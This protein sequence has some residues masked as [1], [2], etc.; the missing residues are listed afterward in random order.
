MTVTTPPLCVE[1]AGKTVVVR[2]WEPSMAV[3]KGARIAIDTETHLIDDT[4]PSEYPPVVVMTVYAGRGIVDLVM[5]PDIPTYLQRL[6]ES[7]PDSLFVFHNAPFDIGV[8]G[9]EQWVPA[10]DQG[11]IVD[12]GLQWVLRRLATQ[13][14]SDDEKEYPSLARVC[15]SILGIELDKDAGVRLTFYRDTPVDDEHAVYACKDAVVTWMACELMGPQTTMDIQVKGFM[16]LDSIRR[17]GMPVDV[18]YQ[19]KLKAKYLKVM[20]SEKIKLLAWGI[21]LDRSR[22]PGEMLE[23]ISGHLDLAKSGTERPE[24]RVWL[25]KAILHSL[26]EGREEDWPVIQ[27]G[28]N[29]K[30]EKVWKETLSKAPPVSAVIPAVTALSKRQTTELLFRVA[31]NLAVGDDA[32]KELDDDWEAHQG[33]PSGWQDKG[34][35]TVLQELLEEAAKVHHLELP[36]T[37]TGKVCMNEEALEDVDPET[38]SKLPFL[39]SWKTFKHAEK[40]CSTF[41]NEKHVWADG[42]VHP[43]PTPIVATGRT[44]MRGPNL[45]VAFL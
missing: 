13:G 23:C 26:L 33:W 40:L 25:L 29:N 44:S 1:A 12:T 21:R 42:R 11:R 16:T 3:V 18:P 24:E 7:C 15:K 17:N 19:R 4:K 14:L 27:A 32:R 34:S 43:R 22:T 36:R 31:E 8:L 39:D 35:E 41:L 6:L 38:L 45:F 9:W 2:R 10:I 37:E 5:W 30:A 20:E 28:W